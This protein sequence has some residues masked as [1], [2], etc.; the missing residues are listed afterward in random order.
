MDTTVQK[1]CERVEQKHKFGEKYPSKR[2]NWKWRMCKYAYN[3]R[4]EN[5]IVAD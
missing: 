1:K 2:D 5:R 4:E 3:T